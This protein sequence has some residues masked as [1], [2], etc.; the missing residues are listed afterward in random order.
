[1]YVEA[2]GAAYCVSKN[3]GFVHMAMQIA[4]KQSTFRDTGEARDADFR[5][6]PKSTV[7]LE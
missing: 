4:Q 7:F 3:D 2:L 1:M 5:I 6:L